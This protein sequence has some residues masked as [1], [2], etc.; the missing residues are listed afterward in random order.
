MRHALLKLERRGLAGPQALDADLQALESIVA[1]ASP[2][3]ALEFASLIALAR[4]EAL[5]LYDAAYLNLAL[6]RACTLAS[7]DS[8]LIEAARRR[9]VPVADLR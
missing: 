7:R 6:E 9:A 3:T 8:G 1:I 4:V 2:P 5:G